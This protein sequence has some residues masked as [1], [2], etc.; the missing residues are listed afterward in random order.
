MKAKLSPWQ[1]IMR[2]AKRGSPLYLN[3]LEVQRL[4]RDS[5][6]EQKAVNDDE[7]LVNDGW[8]TKISDES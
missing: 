1:K 6:I 7:G 4:S 2:A 8:D 3:S 5:A